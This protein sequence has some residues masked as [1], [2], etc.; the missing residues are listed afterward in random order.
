MKIDRQHPKYVLPQ[1]VNTLKNQEPSRSPISSL[2]SI[3]ASQGTSNCLY[4]ALASIYSLIKGIFN[5]FFGFCS[6]KPVE[7]LPDSLETFKT[8]PSPEGQLEATP[9]VMPPSEFDN[10]RMP[11]LEE[12][13]K[14]DFLLT[15]LAYGSYWKLY[16]NESKLESD[17]EIL[18]KNL[19]P[20]RFMEYIL[21]KRFKEFK[22]MAT[23]A[24]M[25]VWPRFT[26]G[27]CRSLVNA[28]GRPTFESELQGFANRFHLSADQLKLLIKSFKHEELANYIIK[29]SK[30]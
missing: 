24:S 10:L 1:V 29:S 25:L 27:L 3:R 4:R 18:R 17:G 14:M 15:T 21:C 20:F 22:T 23:T 11:T 8:M 26:K 19:S 12:A 9:L 6:K 16:Q 7:T 13:N 30:L 2:T 5:Y 28:I